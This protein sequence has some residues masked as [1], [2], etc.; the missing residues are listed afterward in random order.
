MAPRDVTGV[1]PVSARRPW[2]SRRL[3]RL[4]AQSWRYQS[5]RCRRPSAYGIITWMFRPRRVA[6]RVEQHRAHHA[7]V[8][9]RGRRPAVAAHGARPV[10]QSLRRRGPGTRR[11]T[12]RPRS[13]PRSGRR[14][15]AGSAGSGCPRRRASTSRSPF[16]GSVVAL[17]RRTWRGPRRALHPVQE[18]QEVG[19]RLR[20]APRLGDHVDG[21]ARGIER[22]RGARARPRG[23]RCRGPPGA[24]GAAAARSAGPG[25][26]RAEP[27]D[28][29]EDQG[30]GEAG[31]P[32]ALA[33][34]GLD[35]RAVVEDGVE[36]LLR[37]ASSD[38]P[39]AAHPPL[40]AGAGGG[41][42]PARVKPARPT[43]SCEAARVVEAD[44]RRGGARARLR[45][46]R[47]G[48][49]SSLLLT[50]KTDSAVLCSLAARARRASFSVRT[51]KE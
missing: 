31:Q 23:P 13:G 14:R 43:R 35:R 49:Y 38:P 45:P 27:A 37:P 9:I 44:A 26:P 30:V 4:S 51:M 28:A 7:D 42:L 24:A 16:F 46:A 48:S 34:G 21:G 2:R 17:H 25:A 36:A 39:Q 47:R 12:G 19:H 33:H 11:A 22:R 15:W 41:D 40:G 5:A 1:C 10:H 6:M 29:V 18:D 50:P 20:G 32:A 3:P 8:P